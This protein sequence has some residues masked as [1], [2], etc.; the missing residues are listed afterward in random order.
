MDSAFSKQYS[1]HVPKQVHLLG[2]L[3][4]TERV[5]VMHYAALIV[6]PSAFEGWSIGI[7]DAKA[8]QES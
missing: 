8:E 3:A 2:N 4:Y 1:S 7:E 6:H 5:S